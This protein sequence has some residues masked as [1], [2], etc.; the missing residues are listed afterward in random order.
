M[1][2]RSKLGI[3]PSYGRKRGLPHCDVASR[4]LLASDESR[5]VK[6]FRLAR[7]SAPAQRVQGRRRLLR[8]FAEPHH[9]IRSS[10]D[11]L[12]HQADTRNLDVTCL[13]I[14]RFQVLGSFDLL[15]V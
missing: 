2:C 8:L 13:V 10:A 3:T 5:A 7:Q 14:D 15:D 11:V 12:A 4:N 9:C 1:I 6:A